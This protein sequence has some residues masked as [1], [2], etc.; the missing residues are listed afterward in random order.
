MVAGLCV[1]AYGVAAA[2]E[3]KRHRTL[4][5]ALSAGLLL[6]AL[7]VSIW[8]G[9][10]TPWRVFEPPVSLGG[11]GTVSGPEEWGGPQYCLEH[12]DEVRRLRLAWWGHVGSGA[13]ALLLTL[14]LAEQASRWRGA[15]D[16]ANSPR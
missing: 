1:I 3:R 7:A 14:A 16:E 4:V 15:R 12:L 10:I 6:P 9:R 8:S 11:T 2:F 13:L 5:T